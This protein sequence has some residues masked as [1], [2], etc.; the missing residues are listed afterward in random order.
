MYVLQTSVGV[1]HNSGF[2]EHS[3][4]SY[5]VIV[6]SVVQVDVIYV[7]GQCVTVGVTAREVVTH[8]V[9]EVTVGAA[10]YA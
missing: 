1:V 2:V 6:D 3:W 7:S 4:H 8:H 5:S 10:Q 9:D